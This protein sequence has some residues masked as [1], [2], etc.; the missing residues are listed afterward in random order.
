MSGWFKEV[1]APD[2]VPFR[3]MSKARMVGHLLD[4]WGMDRNLTLMVGDTEHDIA[5]ARENK[6]ETAYLL[7]GY[8]GDAPAASLQPEILLADMGGAA[9][10]W[11]GP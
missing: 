9:C 5:A 7:S 8:G 4:K 3:K 10:I 6:I 2:A 1:A 11:P